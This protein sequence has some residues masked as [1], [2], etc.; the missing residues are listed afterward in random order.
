MCSAACLGVQPVLSGKRVG[1]CVFEHLG[2]MELLKAIPDERPEVREGRRGP[3]RGAS[4]EL[5]FLR[6]T[7]HM[8]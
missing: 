8:L 3:L 6:Q 2:Q 4:A 5:G 7:Q 1:L